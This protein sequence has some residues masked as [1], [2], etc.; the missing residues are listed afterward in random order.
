MKKILYMSDVNS[1]EPIFHSQ[2]LPHIEELKKSYNVLLM[3]IDRGDG[4]S[5]NYSYNSRSGDYLAPVA[6]INFLKQ[7]SDIE[8][9]L[10]INDIDIIYSRGFRGGLVGTFIKNSIYKGKKKLINDVRADVLD[11]HKSNKLKQIGFYFTINKVLKNSD[12]LFFVSSYL[13]KKYSRKFK[14]NGPFIICP[15]FVPN[16]K[17]IFSDTVRKRV[18][19]ELKFFEED[20]VLLYSVNLAKWQNVEVILE[21][22]A[23]TKNPLL[24]LLILTKDTNVYA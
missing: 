2:V 9:F 13:Q 19:K 24:K 21:A 11:E 7:R 1:S 16:D 17:F 8:K 12:V 22:F 23:K 14:Y 5:Y 18:R 20:V 4:F 10:S 15:T 3:G 6:Y